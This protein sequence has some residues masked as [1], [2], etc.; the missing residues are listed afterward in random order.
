[1]PARGRAVPTD[2]AIQLIRRS[3]IAFMRGTRTQMNMNRA[4]PRSA[5]AVGEG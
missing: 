1:M 4:M 5:G 2:Q 3:M